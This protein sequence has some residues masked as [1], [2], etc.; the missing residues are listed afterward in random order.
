MAS[1]AIEN[2]DPVNAMRVLR[3][4]SLLHVIMVT[5]EW[6]Q[7]YYPIPDMINQMVA[8]K[9]G[10]PDHVKMTAI[11]NRT[12]MVGVDNTVRRLQLVVCCLTLPIRATTTGHRP[13]IWLCWQRLPY[14]RSL[15]LR[16][17]CSG[18]Y[19]SVYQWVSG[20]RKLVL[21]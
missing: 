7:S 14:S 11:Y 20:S 9:G 4:H 15:Q 16:S 17:S 8:K 12:T 19:R 18:Y 10:N 6:E 2:T 21:R 5:D 13:P 1:V 3:Q